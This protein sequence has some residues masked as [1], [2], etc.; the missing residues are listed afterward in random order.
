[1]KALH[2]NHR[3]GGAQAI[4]VGIAAAACSLP[5]SILA[6]VTEEVAEPF[7]E[8]VA[9]PKSNW[10][11]L[12]VGGASVDGND[13]AFMRRHQNSGDF[14]G[15]IQSF[16]FEH[17]GDSG[18]FEADGHALPGLEDYEVDLKYTR[19]DVGFVRGGY[20]QFRTWYDGSGGFIPGGTGGAGWLDPISPFDD[21]LHIDRGR[22]WFEAGLRVPDIPEITFGWQHDWRQGN[23]DSTFWERSNEAAPNNLYPA[24]YNIDEVRDIFSLDVRHVI[25][26]TEVG[27]GLR[28]HSVRNDDVRY[29]RKSGQTLTQQDINEYDLWGGHI[30]SQSRFAEDKVMLSFAYNLTTLDSDIGGYR[31][32]NHNYNN[33]MGGGQSTTQVMN[34]SLWWNPIEDLVF[35]PSFRFEW[36]NQDMWGSHFDGNDILDQSSYESTEGTAELEVRYS[37]IDC[38]LL[39]C[40]ALYSRRDG[41]MFRSTFDNAV[42]DGTRFTDSETDIQKYVLGANWYPFSR[43]S[44]STQGYYRVY[45][46]DFDSVVTGSEDALLDGHKTETADF[47]V[48]VTWRAM[49]RLTLVTRYD[50]QRTD[51]ENS[52]WVNPVPIQ[53]AEVTKH[54]LTESISWT[55]LERLYMQLGVHW[56]SSETDTPADVVSPG[57]AP[58]WDNDYWSVSFNGGYAFSP[59]TQL[60]WGYYY[61]Q[62][63]NYGWAATPY[64]TISDEHA[65]TVGIDHQLTENVAINARYGYLRGDDDAA[66]GFNDYEAH[67]VSTG[68]RV[69]F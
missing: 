47:N 15:G 2:W 40:R 31:D 61:Y 44:I 64:G 17:F 6:G 12:T 53:S 32:V 36:W 27:G 67:V 26:N 38:A 51:I 22:I 43:V 34:A 28:Y 66:G 13:A 45:D 24:L 37:G 60:S 68:L 25:G 19:D 1:M 9:E 58:D 11:E 29:T 56:I 8:E 48:R 4:R 65:L 23:K 57:L 3:T 54:I 59:E 55:P 46:Q 20:R 7:E 21:E 5:A 30:Y 42:V 41:D 52:A 49:P 39:Y 14:Y 63:D 18:L 62:A 35:V 33:L 16:H 50:F 69:A 10:I